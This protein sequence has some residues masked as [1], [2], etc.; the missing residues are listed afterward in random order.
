MDIFQVN[1]NFEGWSSN[2]N[3]FLLIYVVFKHDVSIDNEEKQT[4]LPN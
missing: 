2:V 4:F 1:M 3:V